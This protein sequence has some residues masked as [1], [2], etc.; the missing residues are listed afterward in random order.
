MSTN[1]K[2]LLNALKAKGIHDMTPLG[3]AQEKE[4]SSAKSEGMAAGFSSV[5]VWGR[6]QNVAPGQVDSKVNKVKGISSLTHIKGGTSNNGVRGYQ[7]TDKYGVHTPLKGQ[8]LGG[9]TA[10]RKRRNDSET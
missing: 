9:Q 1:F 5:P 8:K 6:S 7:V 2:N 4:I 3:D 10:E